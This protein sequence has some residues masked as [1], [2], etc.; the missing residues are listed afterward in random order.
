MNENI[1]N[2]IVGIG[3]AL[4][5]AIVGAFS[6][7]FVNKKTLKYQIKLDND[8][9]EE[10][11][12]SDFRKIEK[13]ISIFLK[14]EILFNK[15]IIDNS[16]FNERI[17]NLNEKGRENESRTSC[18]SSY[19]HSKFEGIKCEEFDKVKLKLLDYV[20]KEIVLDIFDLYNIFYLLLRKQKIKNFTDGEFELVLNLEEK[21]NNILK[22]S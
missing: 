4:I 2:L 22:K 9:L 20:D 19:S 8:K 18:L 17:K 6:T 16:G 7:Y 15:S 12:I 14:E 10:K 13:V 1:V 21:I 5:G 11:K 3:G